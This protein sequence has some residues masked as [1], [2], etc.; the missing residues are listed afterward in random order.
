MFS[1]R[2]SHLIPLALHYIFL[3]CRTL[4]SHNTHYAG[5]VSI[6]V[7]QLKPAEPKALKCIL[8]IVLFHAFIHEIALTVP[9]D[10]T[11]RKFNRIKVMCRGLFVYMLGVCAHKIS[12]CAGAVLILINILPLIIMDYTYTF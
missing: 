3:I 9:R 2:Y 10:F 7:S 8:Q 4:R 11:H 1:M 5:G 6:L 12:S